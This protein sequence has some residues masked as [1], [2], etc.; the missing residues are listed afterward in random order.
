MVYKI[1]GEKT[2]GYLPAWSGPTQTHGKNFFEYDTQH[3][4]TRFLIIEPS[5]Q[6]PSFVPGITEYAESSVSQLV[7]EKLF[8]ELRVQYR[9]LLPR[10]KRAQQK[11]NDE[12]EQILIRDNRYGCF[13]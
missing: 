11:K 13:Y 3:V 1:Y 10:S 7:E 6:Y 2:Y 9:T 8:G 12:Y 4:P 5:N